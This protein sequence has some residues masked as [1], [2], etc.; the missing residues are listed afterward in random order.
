MSRF[1][2]FAIGS[3]GAVCVILANEIRHDHV[4]VLA[5]Q[6]ALPLG[7]QILRLRGEAND[8]PV[9]LAPPHFRQNIRGRLQ[10]KGQARG[11]LFH[12]LIERRGRAI[13]RHGGH[14]H[15][16]RCF[17]QMFDDL[18]VHLR[19]R[20]HGHDLNSR[21]C[22]QMHGSAHH[23][24]LRPAPRRRGRE[25]IAHLAAGTVGDHAHRVNR[26][27]CWPGGNQDV[28]AAQFPASVKHLTDGIG[29][30]QRLGHP[31]RAHHA[32]RKFAASRPN[33][34][35]PT[36]PQAGQV[37]AHRHVIPHVRIHGGGDDHRTGESQI[38]SGEKVVREAMG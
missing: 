11:R 33:D 13:V 12:L 27:L 35:V 6:F 14:G 8:D 2:A 17:G 15:E 1:G 29:N 3:G 19:G 34:R 37:L 38:K 26:F 24:N 32:A 5:L 4:G 9:L 31:A 18:F 36:L 28:L 21:R 7:S 25:R 30:L 23:S 22:R 20:F 10:F 16:D